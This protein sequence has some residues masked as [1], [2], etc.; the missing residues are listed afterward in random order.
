MTCFLPFVA[1]CEHLLEFIPPILDDVEETDPQN[2]IFM[3]RSVGIAPDLGRRGGE[4]G[5]DR[6]L[7]ALFRRRLRRAQAHPY[8]LYDTVDWEV[9]TLPGGDVFDRFP[10]PHA[11]DEAVV[12]DHPPAADRGM[13]AGPIIVDDPHIA[14]PPKDAC[15]NQMESM[16]YHFKLIMDGIQVPTG[17]HYGMVE[18]G[19]GEL[20]FYC[21]S[22]GG[23][24]PYRIK[25]RPPCFPIFSTFTTMLKGHTLSDAI[26]TLGRLNVIAGGS[27]DDVSQKALRSG[28][29]EHPKTT[30]PRKMTFAERLYL[31]LLSGLGVT[32]RHM[33][34]N[35]LG[36]R[37]QAAISIGERREYSH[38][39]RGHHILTTRPDG[40]VRC[41]ACF[42]CATAC[43]AECIHIE[44]AEHPD[45]NI[46]KYP[47]VYEIDML[48]CVF[49]GYCVDATSG[50]CDHRIEQRYDMA[51]YS[52]EQSI[53]GKSDL[54]KPTTVDPERL[55]YRPY[56]PEE[57]AAHAA[58]ATR[59]STS[60]RRPVRR[61]PAAPEPQN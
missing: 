6:S 32:I 61:R 30:E 17:E 26:A 48:R 57:D 55:G 18:G 54:M 59:R 34:V 42:L 50:R 46:E 8:D 36:M 15:Y 49:C 44:A 31:P 53:V 9:P 58:C 14:L 22:D 23:G 29:Q 41:V 47:V 2:R 7:P 25:V 37:K 21:I 5:L 43:P 56:Y 52:R 3:D 60:S 24:K 51:Y 33:I 11:G 19:N 13:P 38:R 20:G 27:S 1:R 35:L 45:V 4:L 16:I 10:H 28:I 12:G 39:Y 40:S